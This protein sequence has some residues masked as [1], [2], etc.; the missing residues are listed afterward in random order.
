MRRGKD[1]PTSISDGRERHGEEKS[2]ITKGGRALPR[3]SCRKGKKKAYLYK[4]KNKKRS[5]AKQGKRK[6]KENHNRQRWVGGELKIT[7][8]REERKWSILSS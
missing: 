5:P 7:V 4:R 8:K 6:K 3:C 1:R 2:R